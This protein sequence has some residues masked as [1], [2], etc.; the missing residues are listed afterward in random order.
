MAMVDKRSP[1]NFPRYE[2]A[3]RYRDTH[4]EAA[5]D[6]PRHTAGQDDPEDRRHPLTW[7]SRV[8]AASTSHNRCLAVYTP[9]IW[10]LCLVQIMLI[11]LIMLIETSNSINN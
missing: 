10:S 1:S 4:W 8:A 11:M 9:V 7:R 3:T 5:A 6:Q 2:G